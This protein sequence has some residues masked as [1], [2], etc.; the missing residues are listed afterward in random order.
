MVVRKKKPLLLS[1]YKSLSKLFV[2]KLGL[3]KYK[4][5]RIRSKIKRTDKRKRFVKHIFSFT[6]IK[7]KKN[8]TKYYKNEQKHSK[9]IN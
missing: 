9:K 8:L 3:V 2:K 4:F 5:K 1:D 7:Q 6:K